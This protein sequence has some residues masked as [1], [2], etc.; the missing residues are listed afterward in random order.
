MDGR[1]RGE[2]FFREFGKKMARLHRYTTE[3]FG[4]Y[5]DNFIGTTP[6][7]NLPD[8]REAID[9]S[10]FYLN[11]RLNYQF[12][13]ALQNGY[14]SSRLENEF[15]LFTE[16]IRPLLEESAELPALL[17]GDLWNGNFLADEEG[18]VVLI[19]PAVYYEH[20]EAELA[21]TLLFGGFSPEFYQAYQQ[22]YPLH[23]AW[24]QRVH[25][26]KM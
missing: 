11:K 15:S 22:E 6:Q 2:L 8:S 24:Q 19:D 10:E 1:A 18:E 3:R 14:I 23:P 20:R 16:R 5:E 21:M 25:L 4:F 26:Y 17:H 13:L 9:W 7:L 12:R